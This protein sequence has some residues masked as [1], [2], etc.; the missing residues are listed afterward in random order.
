MAVGQPALVTIG[1]TMQFSQWFAGKRVFLTGHT[2]FKGAWLSLWLEMIGAEV[3]G[4]ALAPLAGSLFEAAGVAATMTSITGDV[5]DAGRLRAALAEARPDVV[6]HMA[7]QSLVRASYEDPV[8]TFA[9]NVVGTAAVLDAVRLVPGIAATVIVTSDKCYENEGASKAFTESDRMGG[10]DPYSA[11]KGCAELVTAAFVR[12]FFADRTGAVA[13]ARAGNV[14]GGGDWAIDRLIPDLMRGALS[15][16]P[17]PIRR[18]SAVRPWQH[19]L[20]PLRGYLMLAHRVATDR[21]FAGGGWNFGPR[22]ADSVPVG[23][24]VAR[25]ADRWPQIRARIENEMQGPAEAHSLTLDCTKADLELDWRPGLALD[26]ALDLTVD[27][28]RAAAAGSD[29]AALTRSQINEYQ[30]RIGR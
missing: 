20:E 16:E 5:C 10:A 29:C 14:I 17:V 28:Y 18:P 8:G 13:S 12:S 2:G 6:I 23:D 26:E 11:S 15:G 27:W 7:A 21:D 9:T 25:I 4:Y 24:V 19:V 22:L 1:V 30:A 3:T